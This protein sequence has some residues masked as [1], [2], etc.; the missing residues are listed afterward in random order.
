[1]M[2]FVEMTQKQKYNLALLIALELRF[3]AKGMTPKNQQELQHLIQEYYR[4]KSNV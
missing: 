1:M 4:C 3:G 2:D